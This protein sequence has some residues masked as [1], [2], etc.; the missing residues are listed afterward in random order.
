[1]YETLLRVK[2]SSKK[3]VCLCCTVQDVVRRRGKE[4]FETGQESDIASRFYLSMLEESSELL[5]CCVIS[6]LCS[7]LAV[8]WRNPKADEFGMLVFFSEKT[9][10]VY[11]TGAFLRMV[12]SRLSKAGFNDRFRESAGFN[13]R[14]KVTMQFS[15]G[16]PTHR[17]LG[18]TLGHGDMIWNP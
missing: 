3:N 7:D 10:D 8:Q 13:S 4:P 1:M 16:F 11:A 6:G 9:R 14:C 2:I 5:L 15:D 17:E 18:S 12:K